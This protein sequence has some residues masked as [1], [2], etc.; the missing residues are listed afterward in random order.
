MPARIS[1]AAYADM[2]GPTVGDRVR[3]ADSRIEEDRTPAHGNVHDQHA[4]AEVTRVVHLDLG[5]EFRLVYAR[6]NLARYSA[7]SAFRDD[8][9]RSVAKLMKA[10]I[11]L[12]EDAPRY[13]S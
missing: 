11:F 10:N 9:K 3:L 1:R 5:F 4:H 7:Q 12:Q 8:G 2:F 6:E 13:T